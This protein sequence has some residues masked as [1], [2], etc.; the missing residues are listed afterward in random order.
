MNDFV[1]ILCRVGVPVA[2]MIALGLYVLK[3]DKRD[4]EKDDAHAAQIKFI[5]ETHKA[6]IAEL[7]ADNSARMDK[8]TE[9]L[10]NNT[11]A[12]TQLSE[13]IGGIN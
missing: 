3:R 13:R 2:S 5:M 1:E 6:E 9:A 8:L 11:I 12:M 10:N 7:R 4:A